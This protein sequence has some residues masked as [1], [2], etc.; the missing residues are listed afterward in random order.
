[1][2]RSVV[3]FSLLCVL[4]AT[5][6]TAAT[7]T[8]KDA[9]LD[10]LGP[11]VYENPFDDATGGLS[12]SPLSYATDGW[13]YDIMADFDYLYNDD[14][15][16]SVNR[17]D[18]GIIIDF[19]GNDV[20]AFGFD[21]FAT[22]ESFDFVPGTMFVW[23]QPMG[24]GPGDYIEYSYDAADSHSS[25][26]GLISEVAID[27]AMLFNTTDYQYPTLDNLIVGTPLTAVPTPAAA[28][29]GLVLLGIVGG[30]RRR[31]QA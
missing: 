16:V 15:L 27:R 14:G 24:G 29:A 26:F 1:M 7:F 11:G 12:Y 9:F 18:D 22:S 31:R 8:N 28:G 4:T 21:G 17:P 13:A 10:A 30:M 3:F 19:T 20:F 5:T 6:A 25:F 2:I 23:V